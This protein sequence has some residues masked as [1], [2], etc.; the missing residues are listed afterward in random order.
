MCMGSAGCSQ[1]SLGQGIR[2]QSLGCSV[3]VTISLPQKATPAFKCSRRSET[4]SYVTHSC[5]MV[6]IYIYVTCICHWLSKLL[7]VLSFTYNMTWSGA[8]SLFFATELLCLWSCCGQLLL[9]AVYSIAAFCL[10]LSAAHS[11]LAFEISKMQAFFS[12]A[13]NCNETVKVSL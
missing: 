9:K 10:H 8:F 6:Y 5:S 2:T 7:L 11:F 4:T 12:H 1:F 13:I 3:V